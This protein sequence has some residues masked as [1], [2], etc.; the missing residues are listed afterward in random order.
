MISRRNE[1]FEL[2]SQIHS[3]QTRIDMMIQYYYNYKPWYLKRKIKHWRFKQDK[4][5][6]AIKMIC[7]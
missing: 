7:E 3:L 5:R 6:V 2:Y 4:Y 1:V